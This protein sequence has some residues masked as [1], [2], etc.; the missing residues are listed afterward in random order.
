MYLLAGA[1]LLLGLISVRTAFSKP[2]QEKIMKYIHYIPTKNIGPPFFIFFGAV[3]I[4]LALMILE[5][6][7]AQ[8]TP[9]N[10]SK[11]E[12]NSLRPS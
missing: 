10:R 3:C 4:V 12:L 7:D 6:K 5:H 8:R 11:A 1:F 2:S 9:R